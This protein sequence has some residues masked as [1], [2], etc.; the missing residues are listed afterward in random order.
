MKDFEQ[1]LLAIFGGV[2]TLAIISVII[3]KNSQTPQVIQAGASALGN[4]V[5]TAVAP[6]PQT[7]GASTVGAQTIPFQGLG[8]FNFLGGG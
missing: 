5:A 4:V 8:A 2:V 6:L 7:S 1:L 3:S